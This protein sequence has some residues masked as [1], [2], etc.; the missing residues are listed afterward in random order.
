MFK[1]QF[2]VR[3]ITSILGVI[4]LFA[5][6]LT[7]IPVMAQNPTGTYLGTVKDSTGGT[8]AGAAV[9]VCVSVA[10]VEPE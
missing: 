3:R 2:D 7:T 6:I 4:A 9:T 1:V 5:L 8:V 10:E